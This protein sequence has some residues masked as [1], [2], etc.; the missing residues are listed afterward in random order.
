LDLPA[1]TLEALHEMGLHRLGECLRLPRAGLARRLGP[2]L[3]G[4]LDRA[5]G[6]VPDPRPPYTPPAHFA[7]R[8]ALPAE[9]E[10][11]P[12]LLFAAHRLLL[13]LSG[14]LHSR[15]ATVRHFAL[16][17]IHRGHPPSRIDI[18]L[19]SPSRD[20]DHL[21]ELL[22]TRLD[23]FAL[24]AP[25]D[26]IALHADSLV[27]LEETHPDFFDAPLLSDGDWQRLVERL[28]ARLGGD[29]IYG[30]APHPDH[31]PEHAWR[32]LPPGQSGK[33]NG[34]HPPRPLWL[35]EPPLAL[36]TVD[37]HPH[38][39]GSLRLLHGPERIEGGWWELQGTGRDYYVAEDHRHARLWVFHER[40][41]QRWFLH[42]LF[43]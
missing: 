37:G 14:F 7:H 25:V 1:E 8:L 28:Q 29:A 17:L 26:E 11:A 21:Q 15:Q 18:G 2:G 34:D 41:A 9:V 40:R 38:N 16:T 5:L 42:G 39:H 10:T 23:R 22:Q 30:C 33:E 19:L 43:A 13:E 3:L 36:A 35:L 4:Y 6:R 12:A 27:P 24:P 20:A 31:R 32:R